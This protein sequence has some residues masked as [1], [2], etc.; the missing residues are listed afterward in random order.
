[1]RQA[2]MYY[3]QTGLI[4]AGKEISK[5]HRSLTTIEESFETMKGDLGLRPNFHHTDIPTIA[6]VHITVLA[7][8]M[9]AG[10]LK[11]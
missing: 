11:S 10:I 8:H 5:L 2:R 1:M 9:L 4:L 6:H 3:G 7:Y